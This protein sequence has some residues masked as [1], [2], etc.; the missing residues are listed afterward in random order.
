MCLLLV[1]VSQ[2]ND[3]THEPLVL[4]IEPSFICKKQVPFTQVHVCFVPSLDEISPLDFYI[5]SMY[6]RYF[7]YFGIISGVLHWTNLI[8]HHPRT[9]CVKFGWNW[10]SGS[11]EEDE[12]VKSLQTDRQMDRQTDRLM[13]KKR[14]SVKLTW[15][16][17]K[18][19]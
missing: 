12:N 11:G 13:T 10:F 15:A 1:S 16:F 7:G 18:T 2:V 9:L 8:L 14:R 19:C 4:Q 6:F 17:M 5:S 3:V